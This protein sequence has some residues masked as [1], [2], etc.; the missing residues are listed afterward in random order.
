MGKVTA[1]VEDIIK[2]EL[3]DEKVE[4]AQIGPAAENGVRFSG[5][6]NMSNRLNG[7][8]GMGLVMASKNLKAIVV[9]G[10]NKPQVADPK[11]L[12]QLHRAGPKL[13]T[14]N[15]DVDGLGKIGTA[16][17]VMFN[18]TLGT[19]P[20]RNYNEGQFEFAEDISGERMVDTILK[21]RDTCYSCIVRC[22]RVVE[23]SDGP[24]IVDPRY[25]GPEYETRLIVA[26][27]T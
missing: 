14:E 2:Q 19:L 8:T 12:A 3:G 26:F 25:G 24:H 23:V 16:S 10:K 13:S 7:R 17:V 1:E 27:A 18:N 5:I 4:V 11:A 9:R 6:V 22:K 20:T 15:A 21:K